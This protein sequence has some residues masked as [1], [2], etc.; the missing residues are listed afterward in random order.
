MNVISWRVFIGWWDGDEPEYTYEDKTFSDYAQAASYLL[1]KLGRWRTDTC[2]V[3]VDQAAS[4]YE[5]LANNEF[6][7]E[8]FG[9]VEGDDYV[10]VKVD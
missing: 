7:T 5:S 2:P 10:L 6:G 8:W 1:F 3:C 4:E 9:E